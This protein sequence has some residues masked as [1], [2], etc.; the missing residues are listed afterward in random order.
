M[1]AAAALLTAVLATGV[2]AGLGLQRRPSDLLLAA[3]QAFAV[4]AAAGVSLLVVLPEAIDAIGAVALLICLLGALVPVVV[5]RI[6]SGLGRDHGHG[7]TPTQANHDVGLGLGYAALLLHNAVEGLAMA[8]VGVDERGPRW[9]LLAS[10]ALHTVPLTTIMVLAYR[11]CRGAQVATWRALGLGAAMGGGVLLGAVT[12]GE[13][14]A[15]VEPWLAA[16]TAGLLLHVVAHDVSALPSRSRRGR[17][18]ELISVGAAI[19]LVLASLHMESHG[20]AATRTGASFV[21]LCVQTAP[22]VLVGLAIGAL[23]QASRFQLPV[24]WLRPAGPW[25]GALRGAVVGAPLPVCACG[26]LPIADALRR[27]G[28]SA[29]FVVAFL[30]ATPELGVETLALTGSLMGWPFAIARLLAAVLVAV[31]AAVAVAAMTRRA[32]VVEACDPAAL[33]GASGS[34]GRRWR[35]AFD[36]LVHHTVPW[37]LLGLLMAALIDVAV[38]PASVARLGGGLLELLV[39]SA[40]AVPSYVCASSATPLA[41]V[42]VDKGMS[43]GA[44]LAGLLLGPATNVATFAFLVRRYGRRAAFVGIGVLLAATWALAGIVSAWV[45]VTLRVEPTDVRGVTAVDA[46]ALGA[47][48]LVVARGL[49]RSGLAAWL[50]DLVRSMGGGEPEGF[51]SCHDTKP[52]GLSGAGCASTHSAEGTGGHGGCPAADRAHQHAE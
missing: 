23:I 32:T 9:G 41:A 49:W 52:A 24:S 26:V 18:I 44:A 31:L 16:A 1:G 11:A 13:V 4:V 28:A 29:A 27:R 36:E 42:L 47:F 12:S 22:V 43:P 8:G 50:G 3:V 25:G 2:G 35:D 17:P 15:P 10:I 30:L 39:V 40:I 34:F 33:V 51:D 5:E 14:V 48:G 37:V 46:V 21:A 45:P 6:A 19:G 7:G 38:E 20:A